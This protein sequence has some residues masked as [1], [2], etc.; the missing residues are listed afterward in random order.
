MFE[1]GGVGGIQALV[2]CQVKRDACVGHKAVA[3]ELL[4]GGGSAVF[5][6]SVPVKGAI[7]A[8]ITTAYNNVQIV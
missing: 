7:P 4:R 6:V 2:R 8:G 3:F 1:N 5:E